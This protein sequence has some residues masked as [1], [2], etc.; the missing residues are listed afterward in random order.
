[1]AAPTDRDAVL[2]LVA[3]SRALATQTT[4]RVDVLDAREEKHEEALR[5]RCH[6]LSNALQLHSERLV[7]LET[8]V[9]VAG[10]VG[11]VVGTIIASLAAK[12][13]GG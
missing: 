1:M 11:G 12:V 10:G 2:E 4:T 9:W 5:E 8:L 6:K 7:R 13:L 3:T